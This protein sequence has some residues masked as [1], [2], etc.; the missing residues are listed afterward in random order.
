MHNFTSRNSHC[1]CNSGLKFKKCHGAPERL[2][3]YARRQKEALE[4]QR[5]EQQGLGKPI[6]SS[7]IYNK[8]YVSV[9][10]NIYVSDWGSFHDF[11]IDYPKILLGN[12][13]WDAQKTIPTDAQH[14]L[15]RWES[16]LQD[17]LNST[18]ISN[19]PVRLEPIGA[20]AAYLD[21][22]YDLYELKKSVHIESLLIERIKNPNGF[23]GAMY[24]V[25]VAASLLRAGFT[26]E[27]EDESDRRSTHV[28][29]VATHVSTGAKFSVEAKR[30]EGARL[31]VNKLLHSALSKRAAHTRIVF[32]DTNDSRL[33]LNREGNLPLPQAETEKLLQRY[34]T[35]P[36][37]KELP[38]AY[39]ITTHN[40]AEHHLHE[41]NFTS[42]AMLLGF[43]I[44]DLDAVGAPLPIQVERYRKHLPIHELMKSMSKHWRGPASFDGEATAFF[45]DSI[46]DRL[47]IGGRYR[48][49]GPEKVEVNAILEHG[50]VIPE[51]KEALCTFIGPDGKKFTAISDL[52]EAEMEAFE[53]HPATFFGAIDNTYTKNN[54]S[55]PLDYFHSLWE[56]HSQTPTNTLLSQ[57]SKDCNIETLITL[58]Q[59]DLA[60]Y[61][62]IHL[63][64]QE[65]LKMHNR[66]PVESPSTN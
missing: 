21:F 63:V 3:N 16:I 33:Q 48:V 17:A 6:T 19:S 50:L 46:S 8:R 12:Q 34:S 45:V 61:Y 54:F 47:I 64:E 14:L 40:P 29:F 65:L 58:S 25:T 26:L 38:P 43:H 62:C 55:S 32:I 11:L 15:I 51:K 49:L 18:A 7:Q 24:E 22:S 36:A 23:P 28:E 57:L 10:D 56:N 42:S 4:Y 52:S 5:R 53:Q 13:W 39:V 44:D 41:V 60:T 27:L 2:D 31:K 35:D 1:F 9:G 37:G 66:S 30:R 20:V 59:P